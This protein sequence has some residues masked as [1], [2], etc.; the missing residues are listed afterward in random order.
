MSLLR[1]IRGLSTR[2]DTLLRH[3]S[4]LDE[5]RSCRGVKGNN[6]V[7]TRCIPQCLLI[8]VIA[9]LVFLSVPALA[10][11]PVTEGVSWLQTHQN[12]DGSWGEDSQ[13]RL[14][15]TSRAVEALCSANA[16][17]AAFQAGCDWL[18]DAVVLNND[19]AARKLLTG[20]LVG[21]STGGLGA[22]PLDRATA[23]G[24]WGFDGSHY[25]DLLTPSLT[26]L[27]LREWGLTASR[28]ADVT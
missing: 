15:G 6:T 8:P 2:R 22:I 24:G 26:I 19:Y 3:F 18:N 12:A 10:Q 13:S 27:G 7:A 9:T 21:S 16:T 28:G 1:N 14:R 20:V 25:R 17:G 5:E 11:G 4:R 23:E